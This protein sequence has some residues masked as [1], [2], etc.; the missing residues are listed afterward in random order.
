MPLP[1]AHILHWYFMPLYAA[2]MLIV[3][4]ATIRETLRQR[5]AED[6]PDAKADKEEP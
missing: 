1:L 2:P 6:P 3:L 5:R 4:Y